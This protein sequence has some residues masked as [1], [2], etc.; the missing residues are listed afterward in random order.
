M[1]AKKY[2]KKGNHTQKKWGENG[3]MLK[4]PYFLKMGVPKKKKTG[5]GA[6]RFFDK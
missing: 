5:G 2:R 1:G 6:H 4:I 3:H